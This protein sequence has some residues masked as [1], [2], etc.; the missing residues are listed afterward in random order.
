MSD[1]I[2][3]LRARLDEDEGWGLSPECGQYQDPDRVLR[4]VEAKRQ[5]VDLYEYE[6]QIPTPHRMKDLDHASAM[7]TKTAIGRSLQFLAAIYS[8]HPDYHEEWRS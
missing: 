4:E 3:F 6:D 5:I 8:D 7:G 2:Q 1:L